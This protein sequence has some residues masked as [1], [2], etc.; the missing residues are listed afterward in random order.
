MI[1]EIT[2]YAFVYRYVH[3]IQY[4]CVSRYVCTQTHGCIHTYTRTLIM[5]LLK[6]VKE[7]MKLKS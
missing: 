2:K 4:V 6:K 3:S 5:K 7:K 1:I